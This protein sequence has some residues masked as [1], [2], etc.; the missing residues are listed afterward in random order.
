MSSSGSETATVHRLWLPARVWLELGLW[1]FSLQ[2]IYTGKRSSVHFYMASYSKRHFPSRHLTSLRAWN[3]YIGIMSI[4]VNC[5]SRE[6][7]FIY[8]FP[9]LSRFASF[10]PPFSLSLLASSLSFSLIL[11]L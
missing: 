8:L 7:S 5:C 1:T 3:Q 10:L 4:A 2:K 6:Y 9:I 11:V